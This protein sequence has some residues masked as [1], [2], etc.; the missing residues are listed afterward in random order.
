MRGQGLFKLGDNGDLLVRG[1][2]SKLGGS[3]DSSVA[4]GNFFALGT[5]TGSAGNTAADQARTFTWA[6]VAN[7]LTST[8]A[9]ASFNTPNSGDSEFRG[10]YTKLS[11]PRSL[12]NSPKGGI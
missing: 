8:L 5:D 4:T 1:F 2:Y 9:T 12:E 11:K 7:P 6:P 10:Q 3:R